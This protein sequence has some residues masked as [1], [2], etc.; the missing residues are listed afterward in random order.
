[1]LFSYGLPNAINRNHIARS[2]DVGGDR[3]SRDAI[4][5]LHLPL[6]VLALAA[7]AAAAADDAHRLPADVRPVSYELRV[8][9]DF[10]LFTFAGRARVTVRADRPTCRVTMNAA[11]DLRVTGVRVTDRETGGPLTV[12]GYRAT[13]DDERLTVELNG[14]DRCLV[15]SREYAVD[16]EY[17]GRLRDDMAGYYRSS[18][19][20]HGREKYERHDGRSFQRIGR[21][22]ADG[23]VATYEYTCRHWHRDRAETVRCSN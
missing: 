3:F 21:L 17:D 12:A 1:M 2:D 13:A 19:A 22:P 9:T 18:Y 10:A 23:R 14:T 11:A 15:Q 8:A 16:V 20:E 4:M 7:A 6:T 5:F